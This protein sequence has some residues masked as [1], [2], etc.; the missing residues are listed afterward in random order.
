MRQLALLQ[1]CWLHVRFTLILS[2][3]VY[4]LSQCPKYS[5]FE[6]HHR[7]WCI[8]SNCMVLA[9]LQLHRFH[10][11]ILGGLWMLW[12]VYSSR[13]NQCQIFQCLNI[14]QTRIIQRS[15]AWSYELSSQSFVLSMALWYTPLPLSHSKLQGWWDQHLEL[16]YCWPSWMIRVVLVWSHF[17]ICWHP[18]I[19]K[20]CTRPGD[21]QLSLWAEFKIKDN[22]LWGCCTNHLFN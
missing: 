13:L 6:L 4:Y 3:M 10:Q 9:H 21:L 2:Y 18:K 19:T 16:N 8:S 7:H 1:I 5:I 22:Q 15:T 20:F 14:A 17:A 11:Y 12:K